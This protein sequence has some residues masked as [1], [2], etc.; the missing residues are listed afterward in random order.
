MKKL[1]RYL[2]NAEWIKLFEDAM[3]VIL[4]GLNPIIAHCPVY[5]TFLKNL[6]PAIISLESSQC[7]FS[8]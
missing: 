2:A 6:I 3:L 4:L 1:D 8:P 5:W 7:G